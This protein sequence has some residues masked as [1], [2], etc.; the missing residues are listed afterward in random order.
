[1]IEFLQGL[2]AYREAS[3]QDAL[4]NLSGLAAGTLVLLFIHQFKPLSAF[5]H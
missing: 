2:T 4:A 3:F 1:M 5:R